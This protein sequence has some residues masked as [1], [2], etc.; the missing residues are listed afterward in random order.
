MEPFNVLTGPRSVAETFWNPL[1]LAFGAMQ[2]RD[3]I[4]MAGRHDKDGPIWVFTMGHLLGL[5][6]R[7]WLNIPPTGKSS[8]QTSYNIL[9]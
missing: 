8:Y 7:P 6:D 1:L 4:L 2:R 5:F 3:D 9:I